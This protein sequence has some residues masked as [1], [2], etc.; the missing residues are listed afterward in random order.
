MDSISKLTRILQTLRLQQ[1]S[2]GKA[3]STKTGSTNGVKSQG[4][5]AN[6]PGKLTAKVN[7]EQLNRR[8]GDR[9]NR[10][11][12]D[13][14]QGDKAAQLF[15]DSILAWEFGEELLQTESFSKYSNKIHEA[16]KSDVKLSHEF[17][18]LLE[19]LD[20]KSQE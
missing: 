2:A 4:L 5:Q 3:N 17:K 20:R 14:R 7:L 8:I 1:T 13:E 15:I 9:I 19:S 11:A 6:H 12:P 10:L 16:V 18:L